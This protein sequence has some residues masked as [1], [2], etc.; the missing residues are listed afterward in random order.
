MI[1]RQ[2]QIIISVISVWGWHIIAW[3]ALFKSLGFLIVGVY[4]WFFGLMGVF[5]ICEFI[6]LKRKWELEKQNE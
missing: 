4:Q 1:D 5:L 6:A 3:M 2:T